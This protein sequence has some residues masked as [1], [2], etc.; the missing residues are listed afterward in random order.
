M[1]WLRVGVAQTPGVTLCYILACLPQ[2]LHCRISVNSS[3]LAETVCNIWVSE[4]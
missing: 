1:I 4:C 2:L 3:I